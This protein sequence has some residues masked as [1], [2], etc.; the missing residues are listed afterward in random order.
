MTHM[1]RRTLRLIRE[2]PGL[3]VHLAIVNALGLDTALR[4]TQTGVWKEHHAI[5]ECMEY[6]EERRRLGCV[7]Q[8]RVFAEVPPMAKQESEVEVSG[9][10]LGDRASAASSDVVAG[11]YFVAAAVPTGS[12]GSDLA[13]LTSAVPCLSLRFGSDAA[14]ESAGS[15]TEG[16]SAH[17]P[18]QLQQCGH[19]A[20]GSG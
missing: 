13:S 16:R 18:P 8:T 20:C 3:R 1:L 5:Q 6:L 11:L 15:S 10:A 17:E 7:A 12:E 19:K 2:E 14:D 9:S 4:N